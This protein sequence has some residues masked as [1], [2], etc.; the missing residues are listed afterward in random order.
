MGGDATSVDD[1]DYAGSDFV[2]ADDD[3]LIR[4]KI[5]DTDEEY[6]LTGR[7]FVRKGYTLTGWTYVN[8]KNQKVTLKPTATFKNIAAAGKTV[9]LTATWSGPITYTVKVNLDGGK[10]SGAVALPSKYTYDNGFDLTTLAAPT[11]VGYAFGGWKV[12]GV[13]V[14]AL[15]KGGV[16]T[17]NVTIVATWTP[18]TYAVEFVENGGTIELKDGTDLDGIDAL[19]YDEPFSLKDY[20]YTKSGYTFKN[21]TYTGD[22]GKEKAIA[23]NGVIK[24]LISDFDIDR[25]EDGDVD[26]VDNVITLT[27]NWTPNKYT[28]TYQLNG[29]KQAASSKNYTADKLGEVFIA[30]PTKTGYTFAGWTM[31]VKGEDADHGLTPAIAVGANGDGTGYTFGAGAGTVYGNVTLTANYTPIVYDL[32]IYSADGLALYRTY[33]GGPAYNQTMSFEV[34]AS[35]ITQENTSDEGK[36]V[37]GFAIKA[38]GGLKYALNKQYKMSEIVSATKPEGNV[39]NLYALTENEKYFVTVLRQLDDNTP[40]HISTVSYDKSKGYKITPAKITGYTFDEWAGLQGTENVDYTLDAKTGVL[41]IKPNTTEFK[42]AELTATYESN[43]YTV[44]LLPNAKDVYDDTEELIPTA[45]IAGG[46]ISHG[47]TAVITD[48]ELA[49]LGWTRNGYTLAG[50]SLTSNGKLLTTLGGLYAKADKNAVVKVYAIWKPVTSEIRYSINAIVTNGDPI[51]ITNEVNAIKANFKSQKFGSAVTLPTIKVT[52]YKFLG[53]RFGDDNDNVT[54]KAGYATKVNAGNYEDVTFTAEFEESTYNIII[55]TNGGYRA[56]DGKKGNITVADKVKYSADV[57]ATIEALD[58]SEFA[59][60]GSEVANDFAIVANANKPEQWLSAIMITT[61][62]VLKPTKD[63]TLYPQFKAITVGK[64]TDFRAIYA[65]GTVTANWTAVANAAGYE[66]QLATTPLFIFGVQTVPTNTNSVTINGLTANKYYVRVRA[67]KTDSTSAPVYGA[68]S[69]RLNAVKAV[70]DDDIITY[71]VTASDATIF[72][73][74]RKAVAGEKVLQALGTPKAPGY[75]FQGWYKNAETTTKVPSSAIAG[76]TGYEDGAEFYA[77]FTNASFKVSFSWGAGV[78]GGAKLSPITVTYKEEYEGT[79]PV[80]GNAKKTGY[81]FAGWTLDGTNP[82]TEAD[83]KDLTANTTLVSLWTP[84]VYTVTYDP[85]YVTAATIKTPEPVTYGRDYGDDAVA[86]VDR[87]GYEFVGWFTA[88][89]GGTKVLASTKVTTAKDHTLYAH[90]TVNSYKVKFIANNPYG[91][92]VSGKMADEVY[93]YTD[94]KALTANAYKV[95]NYKFVGW[96]LTESGAVEYADKQVISGYADLFGELEANGDTL[97]L[98]GRWEPVTYTLTV[99][100]GQGQGNITIPA[101]YG[102]S[103]LTAITGAANYNT[104]IEVVENKGKVEAAGIYTTSTYTA[105]SKVTATTKVTGAKTYY[106]KWVEAEAAPTTYTITKDLT[107]VTASGNVTSVNKD[108]SF[109][110][111]LTADDEYTMDS[112]TVEMG[113]ADITDTAYTAASGVVSIAKVTGDVVITAVAVQE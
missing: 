64:A 35:E 28:I 91:T 27:A 36:S 70:A 87:D 80:V 45:G 15:G 94:N 42:F 43:T 16:E 52:G 18:G 1:A 33:Q 106:V 96:A 13:A 112:V 107:H 60:A 92:T 30:E 99:V 51:D 93:K 7:E 29:G 25:N 21:W 58:A 88:K 2:V 8:S 11:K 108:A 82:V 62:G 44:T 19:A 71:D 68:W 17:G 81:T 89:S 102:S 23:S 61:E 86:A 95:A 73:G 103:V 22:D 63:V 55:N 12:D 76:E 32:N 20:I 83:L 85:N 38:N 79:L 24:N 90:W 39:I 54:V 34:L 67:F 105:A 72:E 97:E 26:A 9:E 78:T 4:Y 59:K 5:V 47:N 109:T 41:T 50:F 10:Y 6:T 31:A 84:S 113:G 48:E 40:T 98:F 110:T 49:E 46:V 104:A 77:K 101:A 37:K 69:T 56:A 111:T 100:I 57:T 14:N 3:D 75:D 53:W 66:V 65:N 74:T